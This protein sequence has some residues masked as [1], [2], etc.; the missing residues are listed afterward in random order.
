MFIVGYEFE[1]PYPVETEWNP[2]AAVYVPLNGKRVDPLDVGETENLEERL[3]DHERQDCWEK[4][5]TNGLYF[6]VKIESNELARKSIERVIRNKYDL[7]CGD[8]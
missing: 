8:K 2:V 6:A 4:H 3:A 7:P 5:A 1:G